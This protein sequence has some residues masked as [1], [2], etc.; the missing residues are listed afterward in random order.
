MGIK[1]DDEQDAADKKRLHDLG[2]ELREGCPATR[3]THRARAACLTTL[4]LLRAHHLP[5]LLSTPPC[6][7]HSPL[8][9]TESNDVLKR[10]L[11]NYIN[12][13]GTAGSHAATLHDSLNDVYPTGQELTPKL[14]SLIAKEEFFKNWK[15][16]VRGVG[17]GGGWVS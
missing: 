3:A 4:T 14:E 17:W 6:P 12:A 13:L 10:N 16:E 9:P 7:P 11:T 2:R 8:P 1:K 5:P 15:A